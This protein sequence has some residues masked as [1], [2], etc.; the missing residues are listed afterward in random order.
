MSSV[1]IENGEDIPTPKPLKDKDDNILISKEEVAALSSRKDI[2][3]LEGMSHCARDH[4]LTVV[5][6][7]TDEQLKQRYPLA[8]RERWGG[9]SHNLS[10]KYVRKYGNGE[11]GVPLELLL[12][13]DHG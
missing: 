1:T 4:Y 9:D 10:E 5:K 11:E 7:L 2:K 12:D 6:D 13:D 8:C 3:R